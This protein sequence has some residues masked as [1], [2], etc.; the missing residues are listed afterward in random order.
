MSVGTK[1]EQ[2][3]QFVVKKW[4]NSLGLRIGRDM[5]RGANITEGSTVLMAL[6]DHAIVIKK[7][8]GQQFYSE[9]ELLAGMTPHLAH[10]DEL[11]EVSIDELS[12]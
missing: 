8:S 4:G 9:K 12:S 7:I 10:A 5:A 6:S 11:A 3:V 2:P 1:K